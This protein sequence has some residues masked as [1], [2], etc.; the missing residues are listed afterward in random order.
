MENPHTSQQKI[1][2]V[3][4]ISKRSIGRIIKK[5]KFHPYHIQ[6]HQELFEIDYHRRLEFCLWVLEK[7]GE[8]EHFFDFVLFSDEST[9]HNNGLVNRHNF[10]YYS[11]KN[12]N[13]F[14]TMDYQ[15]RWSVNVWGGIVGQHVVGPY[16]FDGHLNGAMFLDFISNHL[17]EL[18]ENIPLHIRQ[19]LWLQLDGAP[20]HFQVNVRNELNRRYPNRW[21][22]RGGPQNWPAR[23]PDLTSPDFFLW[24]HIKSIV[25]DIPPTTPN[26]MKERIR[27]AFLSIPPRMLINVG[28]SFKKR[29]RLCIENDGHHFEHL[30]RH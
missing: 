23:S 28:Q 29:I 10:H 30:L 15:H 16:F 26:N 9:F 21:I 5:Y 14:R 12:P 27:A 25:Y 2:Q 11:D 13:V 7:F 18:L 4:G 22:G 6:L 3:T 20:A 17:P 1:F 19:R 24:G 8:N